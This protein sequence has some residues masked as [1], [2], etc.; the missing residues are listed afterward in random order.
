MNTLVIC[1]SHLYVPTLLSYILNNDDGIFICTDRKTIFDLFSKSALN[2]IA[3]VYYDEKPYK[4]MLDAFIHPFRIAQY[5]RYLLKYYKN[6]DINK[7]LFFH[8]GYCETENWLMIELSKYATVYYCPTFSSIDSISHKIKWSV[9][10]IVHVIFTRLYWKH[11]IIPLCIQTNNPSPFMAQSFYKKVQSQEI[12]IPVDMGKI[13]SS[14]SLI[15]PDIK[16]FENRIVI[17]Q[18]ESVGNAFSK[19]IYESFINEVIDRYGYNMLVFKGHPDWEHRYGNEVKC[20]SVPN[21]IS[22]NIILDKFLLFIGASSTV[23]SEA[24]NEGIPAISYLKF[25]PTLDDH[26]RDLQVT[27]LKGISDSVLYPESK[28]EFFLMVDNILKKH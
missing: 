3:D 10:N 2:N 22:A 9:K 19:E 24:A 23:M 28:E 13:K 16:K 18:C 21:Y 6:K 4:S 27:Y 26:V 15:C 1:G 20:D 7:I 8:D 17:L 12:A 14:L 11:R 5:K 25:L